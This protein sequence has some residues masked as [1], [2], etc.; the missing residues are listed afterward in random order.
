[1]RGRE[2]KKKKKKKKKEEEEEAE[3]ESVRVRQLVC[4]GALLP[5]RI[6]NL[7]PLLPTRA[8]TDTGTDIGAV[9]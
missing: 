7:A 6:D 8:R 9:A 3:V 1:M 2:K 4:L 5:T